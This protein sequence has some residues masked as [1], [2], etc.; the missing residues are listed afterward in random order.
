MVDHA[1]T[2]SDTLQMGRAGAFLRR[3]PAPAFVA[4]VAMGGQ[5]IWAAAE[6]SPTWDEP[7]AIAAGYLEVRLGDFR[8]V[9]DHPPLQG[10]LIGLPLALIGA[11]VQPLPAGV[12]P[13]D[14]A[15]YY[16]HAF[17][18][19]WGNPHRVVVFL[20]RMTVL[21]LTLLAA[22]VLVWWAF[23]LHGTGGAWL[24]ALLCA[25]EPSWITHGHL[26]TRDGLCTAGF[27][28]TGAALV[29]FLRAPNLRRA[30]IA[31]A[32]LGVALAAKYTG[33]LLLPIVGV[34]YL[35]CTPA[36]RWLAMAPLTTLALGRLTAL[37]ATML[38]VAAV[39]VGASYRM[40]FRY[41]LY[42]HG[43]SEIYRMNR[44]GY[45]SYCWG[46]F[47]PQSFSLYY[48]AALA[49]KTPLGLLALVP[50]G[51]ARTIRSHAALWLP[52]AL[53]VVATLLLTAFNRF[54]LGLRHALPVLPMFILFAAGAAR[55][56]DGSRRRRWIAAAAVV[57]LALGA[58]TE[59]VSR[60]PHYLSF[61]NL[62][63]GGPSQGIRFLDDSNIDWGQDLP[64][65]AALQRREQIGELAL[66]YFGTAD[67]KAY[68]VRARRLG[69]R[70]VLHPRPGATY[71]I[72]VHT[73]NRVRRR[74]PSARWLFA[75]PWR[76]AGF[77]IYVYRT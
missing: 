63:A 9:P 68:G 51:L 77:S 18:Y 67:P 22:A 43:L 8:L 13:P 54:N 20:A 40:S 7:N 59:T 39:V 75:P 4:V 1:D 61:F 76:R 16:G 29:A 57:G 56:I 58:L 23:V 3:W 36:A 12:P 46:R 37:F 72:S 26:V 53:V 55:L 28:L 38:A 17:L 19:R 10:M 41:D 71:A 70:E 44:P 31:G 21:L 69:Q 30:L 27:V 15:P 60:A 66:A 14:A 73:L 33:L 47:S 2:L 35:L 45:E 62:A 11:R 52:A 24:A 34:V 50:L 32:A 65:L 25:A 5:A 49:V 64:A 48:L 74:F 6:E 42:L